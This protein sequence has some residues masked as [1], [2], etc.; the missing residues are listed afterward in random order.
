MSDQKISTGG[1]ERQLL[2][3][4]Y[5]Y[6]SFALHASFFCQFQININRRLLSFDAKIDLK[7]IKVLVDYYCYGFW[8]TFF[9]SKAPV[10]HSV[11]SDMKCEIFFLSLIT[12]SCVIQIFLC[13][14]S[15]ATSITL[16]YIYIIRACVVYILYIIF[17]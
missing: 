3:V 9:A 12:M 8:R 4:A 7:P 5:I 15:K 1:Y 16:P 2:I 6:M 13:V 14:Y 17:I 11:I 10:L